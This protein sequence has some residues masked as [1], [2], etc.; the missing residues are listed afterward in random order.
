MNRRN[1]I[2]N[3]STFTGL[4][5]L[6]LSNSLLAKPNLNNNIKIGY[7]V[8]GIGKF[9]AKVKYNPE[10]HA[11]DEA[12]FTDENNYF[13]VIDRGEIYKDELTGTITPTAGFVVYD[14]F[15]DVKLYYKML[16]ECLFGE[17]VK[18]FYEIRKVEYKDIVYNMK[19]VYD[20]VKPKGK[21]FLCRKFK[22][23]D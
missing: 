18:N 11:S 1:F 8:N 4:S 23:I 17:E 7:K 13:S 15:E 6:S 2:K 21:I 20:D 9:T 3:V 5:L 19:Y 10:I 12:Y 22:F 16:K 14:C